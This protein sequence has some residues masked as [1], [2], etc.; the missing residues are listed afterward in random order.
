[1]KKHLLVIISLLITMVLSGCGKNSDD[2]SEST[3]V[4]AKNG[5]VTDVI[6]ESF[7]ETYYDE[8]GLNT[9]FNEKINEF[10]TSSDKGTVSLTSIKVEGGVAKA[11]LEF[12]KAEAYQQFYNS[13]CFYGTIN[14]AYDAG[15]GLNVTLKAI[16]GTD[17]IKKEDIMA[18]PKSKIIIVGEHRNIVTK[19]KIKYASANVEVLSNKNVRISSDASGLAYLILE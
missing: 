10:M 16:N 9:F 14:D 8:A 1:M 18:M 11:T 7:A 6:V 15:Y 4:F 5:A 2:Y 3:L 19:E 13:D 17:T 12:N